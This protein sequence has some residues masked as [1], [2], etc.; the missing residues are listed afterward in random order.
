MMS[1]RR[2]A[3]GGPRTR[4]RSR[5]LAARR[6]AMASPTQPMICCGAWTAA[7]NT[8]HVEERG[9]TSL[10]RVN[11][12]ASDDRGDENAEQQKRDR[13]AWQRPAQRAERE[14]EREPQRPDGPDG[15]RDP[16]DR[17]EPSFVRQC[18][19]KESK[20]NRGPDPAG[21]RRSRPSRC[22]NEPPHQGATSSRHSASVPI[23]SRLRTS[24]ASR[25]RRLRQ[26]RSRPPRRP[27]ALRS[28]RRHGHRA[29]AESRRARRVR[30]SS[31]GT[32][33]GGAFSSERS[34]CI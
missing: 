15:G 8:E 13:P 12:P 28:P 18:A 20:A 1:A 25:R 23:S 29:A 4:P 6:S 30:R 10:G 21:A 19:G 14:H 7:E 33:R 26:S 5:W 34:R 31:P 27:R 16:A 11:V 2:R 17:P 32:G 9:R 3:A 24:A 22:S